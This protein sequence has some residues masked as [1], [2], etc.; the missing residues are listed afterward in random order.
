MWAEGS[1]ENDFRAYDAGERGKKL[2]SELTDAQ[3]RG[4]D[5]GDFN[6]WNQYRKDR[7][8]ELAAYGQMGG[9][10]DMAEQAA[11]GGAPSA[12]QILAGQGTSDAM[13]AQMGAAAQARGSAMGGAFRQAQGLGAQQMTGSALQSG[14]RSAQET[15][16]NRAL[17][18][19]GTNALAGASDA[20]RAS[21]LGQMGVLYNALGQSR[22]RNLQREAQIVGA[23]A[24]NRGDAY[25]AQQAQSARD[26]AAARAAAQFQQQALTAGGLAL[27]K[28]FEGASSDWNDDPRIKSDT[29]A[30]ERAVREGAFKQGAAQVLAAM[31]GTRE[32][33][34]QALARAG[35]FG[36]KDAATAR[37]HRAPRLPSSDKAAQRAPADP[38][39]MAERL[40][41][42]PVDDTPDDA[43]TFQGGAR[44]MPRLP[45]MTMGGPQP[46]DVTSSRDRKD[47]QPGGYTLADAFLDHARPFSY[48]YKDPQRDGE[49][50]RLGVMAQDI[51][52]V[53]EIGE[54]IVK[55]TPGGKVL[56][57]SALLSANT[58][59]L[60]RLAERV[61]ELEGKRGKK[62][63]A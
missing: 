58:A 31:G 49:G 21:S 50:R 2:R 14:A 60:G 41:P 7:D 40:P 22:S 11:R 43:P 63:V 59:G 44:L 19:G 46:Q 5:I 57:G 24:A 45:L 35:A 29:E 36:G 4:D 62:R 23:E 15:A 56:D 47:V 27:Q 17:Y 26:A 9:A 18:M 37:A 13:R 6:W 54:T 10:V 1:D 33:A 39:S 42:P 30:K 52:R 8:S 32:H 16:R 53:P 25:G 38:R 28:G 20:S 12:A 51:E 55:D 34:T 48:D 3:G 61:R